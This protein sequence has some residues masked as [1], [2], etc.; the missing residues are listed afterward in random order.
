[1]RG[2]GLGDGWI[3][4]HLWRRRTGAVR[5]RVDSLGE[6]EEAL[7]IDLAAFGRD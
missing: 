1:V 5:R 3:R 6:E 2:L 4:L 7:A